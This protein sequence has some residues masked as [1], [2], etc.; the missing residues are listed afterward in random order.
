MIMYLGSQPVKVYSGITYSGI[1]L[2]KAILFFQYQKTIIII[3]QEII[4]GMQK[5][6]VKIE[7]T[8]ELSLICDVRNTGEASFCSIAKYIVLLL[9]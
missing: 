1:L 4:T 7:A 8:S 9:E 2:T 3:F 5:S 6:E